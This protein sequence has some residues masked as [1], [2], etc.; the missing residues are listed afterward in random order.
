MRTRS[1]AQLRLVQLRLFLTRPLLSLSFACVI[2][3]W[4]RR[5]SQVVIRSELIEYYD[6]S[7]CYIFRPW[8]FGMWEVVTGFFDAEIKK[9]GVRNAYFPLFI[10]KARLET[11]K[12]H[13][14]GFAPEVAWV[15]NTRIQHK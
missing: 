15:R 6:I 8:S 7:G 4:A 2:V 3:V 5:Y 1:Y 13:V 11:E 10:S 12:D 9:L 14:E